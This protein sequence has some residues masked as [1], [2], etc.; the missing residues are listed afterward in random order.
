MESRAVKTVF[1]DL[2]YGIPVEVIAVWLQVS[3][4]VALK[5]KNGSRVPCPAALELFKL[6]LEGR[7][8]PNEWHGFSFRGGHFFDPERM[9]FSFGLLRAYGLGLQLLREF[10]R[11]SRQ[12]TAQ[13]DRIF[14]E[15]ALNRPALTHGKVGQV[16]KVRGPSTPK[17]RRNSVKD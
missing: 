6:K 12:R 1:R 14:A 13:V 17:H 2:C 15:V 9:A 4:A 8:L 11:G 3:A 16:A 10:S 7:I 5:Y